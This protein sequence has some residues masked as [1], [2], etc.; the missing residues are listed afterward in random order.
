MKNFGPISSKI[1]KMLHGADYNPEQWIDV[2]GIWGEDV[3]LMKLSHSN[4]VAVGIFSWTM[5]EPEEGKFN[6]EW[7]DEV[8]DLMHKNGNHVI[9]ATPS[10]AKPIWMAHKYPET[11]R[12]APNRVRNLYGERHNHCYTSP[13]YREKIAI[14]DRMLAERYKDHPALIMWHISNEFEGQCS[15]PLCEKAFREFLKEKYDNS[16][17]KLNEAWWTKFWSH[18]Y[19]SWDEIEAPAPHGEPALH[20]LNLDWM[21][22]VTHQTL[23]YYK[24]ERSILKEITPDIPV[25]TNFHDYVSLQRGIDYWKFAPYLDVVS[26]DNY[27]YWHGERSDDHEGSRIGFVHDLN[28]ALLNGKPFMMMESS[29]SSTNWQPV[30]KLRRP[31]MHVLSSLQAVAHGSDTVQYFQWRKSRGSSEKFHGAVVD[32]CGHENTR[33]FRDVTRVGEI[34]SKLDE[35]IGTSVEPEVAVIYDWENFWAIDD[36]QGPR[37]EKKD[38][39]DTCQ[40]HYKAFWDM[41]VPV[42]VIN[43]DCD[44]SKYKVVVAPMLYLM[45]PGVGER[46]EEFVSNGGTLITT[47]WSGIVN[48]NDLCFLNGFPGPLRKVTG[49]WAEELDALYDEDVNYVAMESENS[50]TMNGEYEARIFCDLIHSEGAEVLATYKTDFYKGRPALTCNKFGKGEAYYIAFRN[51]DEFLRDFYRSLAKKIKLEKAIDLELPTGVNAQVRR[52]EK[53]EFIFLLNFSDENKVINTNGM[54][55]TNVET[56]EKVEKNI[57]IEAYGVRIFKK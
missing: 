35:V 57:E 43:M 25:T 23:D 51:N 53:N 41:S 4:V 37:I 46:L 54:E 38:Y 49:I 16:L 44:F 7:L 50:L 31:G 17:D 21:R 33:V 42:D 32:H 26:W 56:G 28:R 30:A 18:T 52:D 27:P 24:H 29:P 6:F 39:Y 10:G 8:M 34:L 14:I 15:C 3:R 48:E 2:P 12:V 36:A 45:R 47:Y 11:L 9:L 20:G 19:G 5:L 13:I 22:F 55:L 40:K 1:D